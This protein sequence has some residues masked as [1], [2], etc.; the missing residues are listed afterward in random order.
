MTKNDLIH[1]PQNFIPIEKILK[2]LYHVRIVGLW[3]F[4]L[5]CKMGWW[6]HFSP[7]WAMSAS[8]SVQWYLLPGWLCLHYH[9]KVFRHCLPLSN[10]FRPSEFS[11]KHKSLSQNLQTSLTTVLYKNY[12]KISSRNILQTNKK[13]SVSQWTPWFYVPL[14]GHTIFC[15]SGGTDCQMSSEITP[16]RRL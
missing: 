8:G 2:L 1:V 6:L 10:V 11:I 15:S 7:C 5:I 4:I 14:H 12:T 16:P 9:T 3:L 13:I